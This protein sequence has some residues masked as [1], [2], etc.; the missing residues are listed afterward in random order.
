LRPDYPAKYF[1]DRRNNY[2][3]LMMVL[4]TGSRRF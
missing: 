3:L 4:A 1:N 2:A